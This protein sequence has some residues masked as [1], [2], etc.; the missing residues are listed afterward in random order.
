MSK[1]DKELDLVRFFRNMRMQ[2]AAMIGLLNTN[3]RIYL[4]K[5][6]RLIVH[7]SSSESYDSSDSNQINIDL[8]T[9]N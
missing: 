2:T 7:E 5:F 6:S 3:Q 1:I 4:Q 9:Q 8:A